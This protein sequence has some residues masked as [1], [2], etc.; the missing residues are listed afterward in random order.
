[1]TKSKFEEIFDY[2][3]D[4]VDLDFKPKK[5]KLSSG[6]ALILFLVGGGFFVQT[7]LAANI[8]L[9]SGGAVEFGQGVAMTAA[10]S[11]SDVLTVTP[12][13]EFMNASGAGAHYLKTITVSGIP[14]GCNGVDFNISTYD[15]VTSTA[16][17]MFNAS[18]TVATIYDNAG[19]FQIGTGGSGATVTSSSGTF[20]ITF[21]TPVALAKNVSRLTL[22]SSGHVALNC[23]LDGVCSVGDNGPGGGT[24]FF[25]SVSGFSAPGS[26]CDTNCHYLEVAKSTWLTGSPQNDGQSFYL[27]S[28]ASPLPAQDFSTTFG[29]QVG[30]YRGTA[31]KNNWF[32]GQGFRNTQLI[33]ALTGNISAN[34]VAVKARSFAPI[35]YSSTVGQW[36]IPSFNE[37]NELCKYA[38][39]QTTGV[40]SRQCMGNT[41]FNTA[42]TNTAEG[43]GGSTNY[44]SSSI[45]SGG[46]ASLIYFG[47]GESN[48]GAGFTG[49]S[50]AARPV[51]VF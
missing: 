24:V 37:L 46:A 32:I 35:G 33:A 27:S 10:C 4:P 36:F 7:T 42:N 18:K 31:E 11:G 30:T 13:S 26:I 6:L 3:D 48:W 19:T 9:N 49:D 50:R 39:G 12:N 22:Q 29:A 15:S 5:K 14:V 40:T 23:L 44:F 25:Y 38:N 21:T 47:N 8:S 2:H 34:S 17:S 45:T 41:P 1:M 28:T 20:T 51:R 43:F 16:L